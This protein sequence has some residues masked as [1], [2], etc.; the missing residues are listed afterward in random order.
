LSF[1]RLNLDEGLSQGTIHCILQDEKGLLWIGTQDGL[2]KFDGYSFTVFR[3]DNQDSLSISDNWITCLYE[4][5]M[6]YLWIGTLSGGV[7][8]YDRSTGTFKQFRQDDT[9]SNLPSDKIRYIFEDSSGFLWVASDYGLSKKTKDGFS[10]YRIAGGQNGEI[11]I[12]HL[13]EMK[14]M[15]LAGTNKGFYQFDPKQETLIKNVITGIPEFDIRAT[16]E[17][18]PGK[19]LIGG[20]PGLY[21][22]DLSGTGWSSREIKF[23]QIK[24]NLVNS[25][26]R[27]QNGRIWV[28]YETEGI[29]LW[30]SGKLGLSGTPILGTPP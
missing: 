21:Q 10:N 6:G 7:N 20:Y 30:D 9:S 17:L 27:D 18:E 22:I 12:N 2:N 29:I 4:D 28:G 16:L 15:I 1:D 14:N 25:L 3:Y 11:V 13:F 5:K 23:P 26:E 24:D 19:I 8:R